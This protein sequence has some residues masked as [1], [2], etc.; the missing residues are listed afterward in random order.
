MQEYQFVDSITEENIDTMI[1]LSQFSSKLYRTNLSDTIEVQLSFLSNYYKVNEDNLNKHDICLYQQKFLDEAA[2]HI[3]AANHLEEIETELSPL[4][5]VIAIQRYAQS[6]NKEKYN[7]KKKDVIEHYYKLLEQYELFVY[8]YIIST[9]SFELTCNTPDTFVKYV[10]VYKKHED[11]CNKLNNPAELSNQIESVFN[12]FI[13]LI[14]DLS[15]KGLDETSYNRLISDIFIGKLKASL[16]ILSIVPSAG[17]QIKGLNDS[18]TCSIFINQCKRLLNEFSLKAEEQDEIQ[19]ILNAWNKMSSI[20]TSTNNS[21][22]GCLG[23]FL[24]L[25]ATSASIMYII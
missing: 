22:S 25:L 16:A 8:D 14:K 23:L 6:K 2:K 19:K 15:D 12:E 24:L 21:G 7:I 3:V 10:E 9:K 17:V 5:L 11:V 20:S 18:A 4:M 1:A 13:P